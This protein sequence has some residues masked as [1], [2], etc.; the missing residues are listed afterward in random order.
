MVSACRRARRRSGL[1]GKGEEHQ[2][3][4]VLQRAKEQDVLKRLPSLYAVI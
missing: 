3:S 4:L 1:P 2:R